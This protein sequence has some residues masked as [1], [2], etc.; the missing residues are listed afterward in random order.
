[1]TPTEPAITTRPSP[2]PTQRTPR[3]TEQA[4][5][6]PTCPVPYPDCPDRVTCD[7]N[8]I[9]TDP[10]TNCP[11]FCKKEPGKGKGKG[12]YAKGGG[13]KGQY[14]KGVGKGA[15]KGYGGKYQKKT[16]KGSLNPGRTKQPKASRTSGMAALEG[17]GS[18]HPSL[19]PL[20]NSLAESG[21]AELAELASSETVSR[22]RKRKKKSLQGEESVD[23][24]D[25]S[26][27]TLRYLLQYLEEEDEKRESRGT[28][29]RGRASSL[30]ENK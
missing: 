12:H 23:S 4:T 2:R 16:K 17:D 6:L 21:E 18:E 27:I 26:T 20:P 19:S 14:A 7:L 25:G 29:L 24:E 10:D 22:Q 3:P 13:A 15:G 28:K 1:M 30:N 8:S 11:C 9:V 5:R